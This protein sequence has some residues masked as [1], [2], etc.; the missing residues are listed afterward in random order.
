M[1][2]YCQQK[3]EIPSCQSKWAWQLMP[4]MQLSHLMINVCILDIMAYVCI[5]LTLVSSIGT[6]S[7]KPVFSSTLTSTS[8]S[9]ASLARNGKTSFIYSLSLVLI[10]Y[11][12][13]SKT[14]SLSTLT[15]CIRQTTSSLYTAAAER[16]R[17][18]TQKNNVGSIKLEEVREL[19]QTA[20]PQTLSI[21][22]D[23]LG[24]S[25][26]Q[27][28]LIAELD[29]RSKLKTK[30][31]RHLVCEYHMTE[32]CP[33]WIVN[34]LSFRIVLL[35]NVL[36]VLWRHL[37]YYMQSTAISQTTAVQPLDLY[38]SQSFAVSS[39]TAMFQ[40]SMAI[41]SNLKTSSTTT[42]VPLLKKLETLNNDIPELQASTSSV[43]GLCTRIN[44]I[45]A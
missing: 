42:L 16:K 14:P 39:Q 8:D 23:H 40:P 21:H 25:Q 30:Q 15:S 18:E 13:A 45:I 43:H 41:A 28:V 38:S 19:A 20:F 1:D 33:S 10:C 44:K 9:S 12:L 27:Q 31:M 26:Q 17:F 4:R 34:S 35:E 5:L 3:P 29:K 2:L 7:F 32:C 22:F 11:I 36:L 6:N 37:E 24:P